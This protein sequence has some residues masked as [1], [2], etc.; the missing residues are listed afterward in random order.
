[1]PNELAKITDN[2]PG[3]APPKAI[4]PVGDL[5]SQFNQGDWLSSDLPGNVYSSGGSRYN[6]SPGTAVNYAR[7]AGDLWLNSACQS[8]INWITRAWPESY[9]CV[10]KPGDGGKKL[11]VDHPLTGILMNPNPWDDDTT[12]W[13]GTILSFWVDGNAYWR[14]NRDRGGRVGEFEYVPHWAISPQRD[15][16]SRNPGPDYYRMWTTQGPIDVAPWDVVHYRFGKDPYNDLLGMSQW[17]SANCEAYT[18][19]ESAH[20]TATTMRNRGTPWMIVSPSAKDEGFEDPTQVRDMIEARTT[21]DNRG[22]VVV[23]DIGTKLDF[24]GP[25]KDMGMEGL[26]QIPVHRICALAGIAVDSIDLGDSGD[27]VTFQNQKAADAKSWNTVVQVQRMMGRQLTKQVLWDSHNYNERPN[28]LFAGFD[29][30]EVRALEVQRGEEWGRYNDALKAGAITPD[31]WRES[32]GYDP[33]TDVQKQEIEDHARSLMPAPP[34]P[35]VMKPT[36][37]V[38]GNGTGKSHVE[39]ELAEIVGDRIRRQIAA[40]AWQAPA[41]VSN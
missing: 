24:P 2:L 31:E 29:Y 9:P 30:S 6:T 21:G 23:L 13:G 33:L 15:P 18:D 39:P 32:T 19:N 41:G 27:H 40:S 8:V 5:K 4:R 26:R 35:Q 1:M 11:V 12:I 17:M 28:S 7:M 20:F 14:I 36:A 3:W 16:D 25:M 34:V 37:D 22:R 38:G 10:K